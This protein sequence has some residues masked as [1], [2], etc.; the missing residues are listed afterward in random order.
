MNLLLVFRLLRVTLHLFSGGV[1]CALLFPWLGGAARDRHIGRWSR[2]LL[3][4]CGVKLEQTPG[5]PPVLAGAMVIANHVSWLDIFVINAVHPCRFV[6]KAEIRD[7][8]MMGWLAEKAGTVFIARAHRRELQQLFKQLVRRLHA[9]QRIAFFPEG[10]T[11]LPGTLLPFH[12]NLFEAA[13]DAG[14]PVQ[15]F[16]LSYV[17]HQGQAHKAVE[18]VGDTSFA[19]SIMAILGGSPVTAR[20]RCLP[21]I[22]TEGAHR[23]DVAQ[24]S[25]R[26]IAAALGLAV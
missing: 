19:W 7:W 13:I 10:T 5:A 18:Y 8:P 22:A 1:T 26:A 16:A 23:R 2:Q 15:A 21:A 4:M 9:G 17:D 3:G 12:A 20:L 25:R 24:A 11:A 14:V 6:A